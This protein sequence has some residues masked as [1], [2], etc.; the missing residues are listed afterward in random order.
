MSHRTYYIPLLCLFF[1]SV[2]SAQEKLF[3][4]VKGTVVDNAIRSP[5]HGAN[6]MFLSSQGKERTVNSDSTGFFVLS[7]IPVGRQSIR[8][9]FIGYKPVTLTNLLVESGKEL[10]LTIEMEE[11][12][13]TGKEV[14]VQSRSNKSRPLNEL[15]LVSARMFS[16]EET[17]RYAAGLNDPS[18]IA[19]AFAGVSGNGDR[20]ALIIRGN[21]PNGLLWRMEGVDIPNPNHF[22]RVGTSG[23]GISILS[24]QL[25]ANSD[26]MTA[27]FPAEYG[28]ALSGVFD[29]HLR[30]GNKD[31]REHT[32]S[33]STIGVDLATEG[34]FKKGSKSSYLINY[35]YG[36]LTLMQQLGFKISDAATT[37]Q[38]LSFNIHLSTKKAGEFS[39]FGF[40]G[41]SQQK[42]TAS[43]DSITWFTQPS[44]RS[45][46]LDASNTGMLAIKHSIMLGKKT[47]LNT[48]YS[49]NGTNY[50]E[51]DNRFDK[52]NTPLVVSRNNQFSE[53]NAVL[54]MVV[55]HK[56]NKHHLLKLGA[57]TTGN[58]F[59]LKQR[60]SVSNLLR[61]KIKADGD[62]RLTHVFAQWKWDPSSVVRFQAG[63]HSQYFSLNK[64]STV[65]P[66]VGVRYMTAKNQFLSFGYGLHAQ[67]QPLGNY[68]VRVK[69][70]TDSVQ[71]NKTMDFSRSHHFVIGYSIQFAQNW[72]VKTEM[73]YQSLY[74]IPVSAT[75]TNSYSVINQDDDYA[76]E[77]LS[78]KGK[79]KNYGVEFTLERYWNDQFYL[80][81]SLSL[82]QSKY[83]PSDNK[84]RNTRFNSNESWTFLLGKEWNLH[85]KRS[86]TLGLDLKMI[87]NGGVRVTP[88]DLHQSIL[89]KA[90]VLDN[91]RIYEEKLPALFRIDLQTEWRVQYTKMTGSLIFGIQ[92]LMNR[93]NPVNQSYD[94]SLGRV[95]YTYLL[96]LIPVIGYKVD[97]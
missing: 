43:N 10:V 7:S 97:L 40:G 27:A 59:D 18:R 66:R 35:R 38:D 84:W 94:A 32:F 96:G 52:F 83:L 89:Q 80:L 70:G 16:V 81:A 79:G 44:K 42:Q 54:S 91:N 47:L 60:E 75:K 8:I 34:Y 20:N 23:G 2:L 39:F 69:I 50:K 46:R 93:Q 12:I 4:T 25:L 65:E 72:N 37:F 22:A 13:A 77:A 24:A 15:A 51:E 82:Y 3:Q 19:T 55:T 30:K 45:G 41:L 87:H 6:I 29:I 88:I 73:Y 5:L 58:G 95:K 74:G 26:F 14:I 36:F 63:L 17:R 76:I 86:S 11:S 78:N 85:T 53:N 33:V 62:T 56:I 57:Y 48:I 61:D 9:S 49:I 68:F 31:K 67:V 21:A 92:N 1:S 64:T 90:T 71:P 28:N